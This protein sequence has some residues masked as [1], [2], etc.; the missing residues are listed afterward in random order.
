MRGIISV[1]LLSF[2]LSGCISALNNTSALEALRIYAE[3]Y[4]PN[5]GMGIV[6]HLPMPPRDVVSA[7]ER[8]QKRDEDDCGRYITLIILRLHRYYLEN[9]RQSYDLRVHTPEGFQ[10]DNPILTA[11]CNLA[12][13]DIWEATQ[14]ESLSSWVVMDWVNLHPYYRNYPLIRDELERVEDARKKIKRG[15]FQK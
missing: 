4:E 14:Q 10:I 7:I 3:T 15:D 13:I 6:P 2:L 1:L 5:A 8:S 12:R 11:F 9:F